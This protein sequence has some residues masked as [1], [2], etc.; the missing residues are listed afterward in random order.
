MFVCNTSAI[1]VKSEDIGTTKATTTTTTTST[2]KRSHVTMLTVIV[3]EDDDD[4]DDN[5][6]EQQQQQ[7][8]RSSPSSFT[9]GSKQELQLI[10]EGTA[11]SIYNK[12]KTK[13]YMSLTATQW[14]KLTSCWKNIDEK[15]NSYIRNNKGIFQKRYNLIQ[16]PVIQ[17]I[18]VTSI[19][20]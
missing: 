9:L 6:M 11:V 19:S 8:Q 15:L 5:L 16:L 12:N 18:P 17:A 1:N 14:I 2:R 13:K 4:D 10:V 3:I 7:Q 20:T